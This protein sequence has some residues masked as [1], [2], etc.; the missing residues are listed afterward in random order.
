MKVQRAESPALLAGH[1]AAR[2]FFQSCFTA[3]HGD[4]HEALWVAHVDDAARC[5]QLKRY[6]C[7]TDATVDLPV[8]AIIADAMRLGSAGLLLAHNHPSGTLEPSQADREVTR[9]LE[10]A[11]KLLG[12]QLLD[13]VIVSRE[14]HCSVGLS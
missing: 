13:H 14:G 10:V 9:R 4:S 1:E 12:I 11:G 3:P 7:G 2:H 5:L 6:A 8:R